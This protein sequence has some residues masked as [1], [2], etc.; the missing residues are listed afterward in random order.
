MSKLLRRV[1]Y[2][3]RRRERDAEL[4]EEMEFHRAMLGERA[5]GAMGNTTLA[6]E[7]AR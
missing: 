6:R 7:D 5:P 3:L 2:W 4:A 1:E